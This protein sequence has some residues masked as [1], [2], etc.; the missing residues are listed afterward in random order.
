MTRLGFEITKET[1]DELTVKIPTYRHDV[2]REID[3]IEE[4]ARIY[5]YDKL[6][7]IPT[8]ASDRRGKSSAGSVCRLNLLL[9]A[10][11]CNFFSCSASVTSDCS[12][13]ARRMSSSFL[14]P[15]VI[16]LASPGFS[17]LVLADI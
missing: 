6:D 5:G 2:E 1:E 9:A 17:Q 3:L 4:V 16:D 13:N 15:T 11:T 10:R 8:P 7:S 14:A 12:G